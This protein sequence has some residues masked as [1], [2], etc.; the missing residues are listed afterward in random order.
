VN[1]NE[2]SSIYDLAKIDADNILDDE[3]KGDKHSENK[4]EVLEEYA[5]ADAA[6][7]ID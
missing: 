3:G 4:Y 2:F 5:D 7:I 1:N 6:N